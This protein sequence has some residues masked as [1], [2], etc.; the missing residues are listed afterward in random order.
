[1]VDVEPGE[2]RPGRR[3]IRTRSGAGDYSHPPGVDGRRR[4][5]RWSR[6]AIRLLVS[7]DTP[8]TSIL[9][10]SA[11]PTATTSKSHPFR[12]ASRFMLS[13]S[14]SWSLFVMPGDATAGG[15]RRPQWS[16][17]T[18]TRSGARRRPQQTALL[19]WHDRPRGIGVHRPADGL[20]RRSGVVGRLEPSDAANRCETG[21]F[22]V[23]AVVVVASVP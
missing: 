3:W 23:R 21:S 12:S 10:P 14:S 18:R 4:V 17:W 8:D 20:S 7:S 11:H 19:D 9:P 6:A 5:P 22:T 15:A 16:R 1:M 2:S 13:G